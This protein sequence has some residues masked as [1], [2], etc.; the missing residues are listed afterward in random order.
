LE[1]PRYSLHALAL[2]EAQGEWVFVILALAGYYFLPMAF[3]TRAEIALELAGVSFVRAKDVAHIDPS[4][5][6]A[7]ASNPRVLYRVPHL[8]ALWKKQIS[9][10]SL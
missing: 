4:S 3:F 6:L 10:P 7:L 5:S 2:D 8:S 1:V 9:F